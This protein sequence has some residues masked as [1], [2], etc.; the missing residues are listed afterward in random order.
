MSSPK[1]GKNGSGSWGGAAIDDLTNINVN[2]AID[3][4]PYAS[5][6][7]AGVKGRVVGHGDKEGT[8]TMK[9]DAVPFT[10]GDSGALILKSDAGTELY[11]G[12]AVIG[13]IGYTVNVEAGD[14]IEANVEWGN[15]PN[16]A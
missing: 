7:T 13:N 1:S 10:K 3:I 4:H 11:N 9:A 8:F 15:A 6:S 16:L 5:S 14:I 2:D 12:V